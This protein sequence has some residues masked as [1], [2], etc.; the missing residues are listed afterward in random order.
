MANVSLDDI[1]IQA[2][3]F[4]L[5]QQTSAESPTVKNLTVTGSETLSSAVVAASATD[6][7]VGGTAITA[8]NNHVTSTGASQAVTLPASKPGLTITIALATA[9]NAVD[10]FPASGDAINALGANNKI[11]MGA[12]TSASFM[13]TIAGQWFTV[14]RVPS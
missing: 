1:D 13:C 11:T 2:L 10:V 7:Q 5:A 8:M 4:R 6:T 14:P 3:A 9:S 12:L